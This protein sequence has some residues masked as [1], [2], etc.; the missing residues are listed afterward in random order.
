MYLI[1]E[2]LNF[3]P[4]RR[5]EALARL[6]WIHGLM[7]DKPGF[8]RALVAKY[9]GDGTRHTVL[10]LWE[11]ED[12]FQRFRETPDGNYGRNRPEG[13]YANDQVVPRWNSVFETA[14]SGA[15]RYLVKV[16]REVPEGAWG[17]FT[18]A[19]KQMAAAAIAG[20]RVAEQRSFRA[21]DRSEALTIA[22]FRDRAAFENLLESSEYAKARTAMP[23][24]VNLVSTHCFEV[25]SEVTPK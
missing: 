14:G 15:G 16:Q 23:E 1:N 13:L 19:W 6:E 25:V 17:A 9:L 10:R 5:D 2:I 18:E 22:R 21:A 12:A 11:S 24:G 20:G 3:A 7:A 4:G 8:Y